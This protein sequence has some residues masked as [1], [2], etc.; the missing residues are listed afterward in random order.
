MKKLMLILVAFLL[1]GTYGCG[2]TDSAKKA[3]TAKQK[4]TATSKNTDTQAE[5]KE[6]TDNSAQND[7]TSILETLKTQGYHV[8]NEYEEDGVTGSAIY[9]AE[10]ENNEIEY[11][12]FVF[13]NDDQA[14][15]GLQA[16]YEHVKA[17]QDYDTDV[18]FSDDKTQIEETDKEDM[19]TVLYTQSGSIIVKGSGPTSQKDTILEQFS[20]WG[21]LV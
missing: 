7:V 18:T 2:N 19:E 20:N 12:F 3:E 5:N 1:A 6:N 4:E 15:Q 17:D 10:S 9:Q 11:T 14:A 8:E 13:D 21:I 16:I